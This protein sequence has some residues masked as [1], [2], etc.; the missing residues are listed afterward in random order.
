MP[1]WRRLYNTI[2]LAFFSCVL[3]PRWMGA[4]VG[5]PVHALLGIGML[6]VTQLNVRSLGAM[7]VPARLKRI[8]KAT[9]MFA[10]FQIATGLAL[11][12]VMHFAPNLSFVSLVLRGLHVVSALTILAQASSVATA[13]D[14]WEEKEF[15]SGPS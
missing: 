9:A 2:W 6:A 5:L 8:S 3:I 7:A 15:G 10:V 13:Y 4:Y 11:G 14:M 12:A 1:L